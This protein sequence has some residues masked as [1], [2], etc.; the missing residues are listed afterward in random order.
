MR[1]DVADSGFC[2]S[3]THTEPTVTQRYCLGMGNGRF[4]GSRAMFTVAAC[5]C[6]A[7]SAAACGQ[8]FGG[9]QSGAGGT[10]VG[11]DGS[12]VADSFFDTDAASD[13]ADP[14]NPG[15][16]DPEPGATDGTDGS[17]DT[18]TDNGIDTGI[19]SDTDT[20]RDTGST[21]APSVEA[22]G[23]TGGIEEPD[24]IGGSSTGDGLA[25]RLTCCDTVLD[26]D[27][28]SAA[29]GCA[30]YTGKGEGC[31]SACIGASKAVCNNLD[32]CTPVGPDDL[33]APVNA[34]AC[35]PDN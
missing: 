10:G 33:C 31:H 1:D 20:G 19:D 28:C 15:S 26:E 9:T 17:T 16:S 30:W 25:E 2:L 6:I 5:L 3:R 35:L 13:D 29:F 4:K 32:H 12:T 21:G 27:V 34:E 22:T 8:D 7:A 14:T 23:T 11:D 18:G 24:P